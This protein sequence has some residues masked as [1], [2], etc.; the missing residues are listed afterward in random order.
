MWK[1]KSIHDQ[2]RLGHQLMNHTTQYPELE[3]TIRIIESSSWI[4]A[5]D[6]TKNHTACPPECCPDAP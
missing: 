2:N 4:P 6:T 5:Q 3:G 1:T